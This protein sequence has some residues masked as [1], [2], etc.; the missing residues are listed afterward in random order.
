MC[1]DYLLVIF[2]VSKLDFAVPI[3]TLLSVTHVCFIIV[4]QTL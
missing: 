2:L 3:N 1:I 4:L